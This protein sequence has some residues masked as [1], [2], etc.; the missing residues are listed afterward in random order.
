[1]ARYVIAPEVALLLVRD[2]GTASDGHRLP[3][4]TLPRSQLLSLL[5]GA[6]RRGELT[7]REAARALD[8]VRTLRIRLL[9]DRVLRATAWRIAER[10]GL[11][12]TPGAE[13]L[14]PPR[15]QGDALVTLGPAL[16]AAAEGVVPVATVEALTGA[17]R[18]GGQGLA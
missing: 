6:A 10:L 14:A 12:D 11:P 3:A 7:E 17:R 15:L 5:H 1:M 2:G 4:P 16:A 13:S 18:P 8:R 9:G